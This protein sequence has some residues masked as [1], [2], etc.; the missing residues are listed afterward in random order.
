MAA[1][2]VLVWQLGTP[3]VYGGYHGYNNPLGTG[4]CIVR[5]NLHNLRNA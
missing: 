4:W 5:S 1:E 3:S 2:L